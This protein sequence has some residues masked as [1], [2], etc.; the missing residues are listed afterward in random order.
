MARVVHRTHRARK[1][2][3]L[4]MWGPGS[5]ARDVVE[6][7]NG[8]T[9]NTGTI[10]S[11]MPSATKVAREE[12]ATSQTNGGQAWRG[13]AQT[14]EQAVSQVTQLEA[15][16]RRACRR[17]EYQQAHRFD[18]ASRSVARGTGAEG[19]DADVQA[20]Q[21]KQG[22]RDAIDRIRQS[23]RFL[24]HVD[25]RSGAP[26]RRHA[27]QSRRARFSGRRPRPRARSTTCSP[28]LRTG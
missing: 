11:T 10:A 22:V 20:A 15:Q 24:N 14:V 17:Q 8:S 1:I 5:A 18:A 23:R 6:K 21:G 13:S 25:C 27:R 9:V 3:K 12:V 19:Q 28:K 2:I 7:V 16:S 4:S 26:G